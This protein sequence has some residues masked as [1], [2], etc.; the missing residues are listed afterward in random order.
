MIFLTDEAQIELKNNELPN[1]SFIEIMQC[2]LSKY[3]EEVSFRF[4]PW[5]KTLPDSY[6]TQGNKF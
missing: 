1:L 6:Q 5:K 3:Q 2:F 4:R